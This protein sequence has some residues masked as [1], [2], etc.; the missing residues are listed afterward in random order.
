MPTPPPQRDTKPAALAGALWPGGWVAAL[1]VVFGVV[2]T[3]GSAW[4]ISA[5]PRLR[6]FEPVYTRS[7]LSEE[8][9]GG[10]A[11][12]N[13]RPGMRWPSQTPPD[14]PAYPDAIEEWRSIGWRQTAAVHIRSV[15][16]LR[17]ANGRRYG[18]PVPCLMTEQ[19]ETGDDPPVEHFDSAW[20][21]GLPIGDLRLP[22]KPILPAFLLNITFWTAIPW[23]GV[24]AIRHAC[25]ARRARQGRCGNCRYPT[26]GLPRC[27]E[28]GTPVPDSKLDLVDDGA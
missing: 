9:R 20:Q 4:A 6:P 19:A 27:P 21:T 3:V 26:L 16:F 18:L 11:D 23:L 5:S 13:H 8:V 12:P 15:D 7:I 2:M 25:A 1:S 17:V 22:I 28:C 14:W 24:L 10:W